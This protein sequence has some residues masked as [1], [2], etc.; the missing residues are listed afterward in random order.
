[1]GCR[2][3]PRLRHAACHHHTASA[4]SLVV[5]IAR[6]H[7]STRDHR[8]HHTSTLATAHIVTRVRMRRAM[9]RVHQ[10]SKYARPHMR[11]ALTRHS[12]SPPLEHNTERRGAHHHCRR[13]HRWRRS[14]A[15]PL[16]LARR[17]PPLPTA[18]SHTASDALGRGHGT[19]R[20][21]C[22]E[23]HGSPPFIMAPCLR[24]AR[25]VGALP[26]SEWRRGGDGCSNALGGGTAQTLPLALL[27]WGCTDIVAPH[28]HEAPRSGNAINSTLNRHTVCCLSDLNGR[29]V[30]G[31]LN[32]LLKLYAEP[33]HRP[34]GG[35]ALCTTQSMNHTRSCVSRVSD[36]RRNNRRSVG[37][38]RAHPSPRRS[39]SRC[40]LTLGRM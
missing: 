31:A 4:H 29:R 24:A 32:H 22:G 8:R 7:P 14:A 33:P 35:T 11:R 13:G 3:A 26:R 28:V 9:R 39:G 17:R 25:I 38:T 34:A 15:A 18:R 16:A 30:R 20:H 6:T 23:C 19:L 5:I 40:H 2:R 12:V 27:A 1:M 36:G 10:G 21:A 37:H